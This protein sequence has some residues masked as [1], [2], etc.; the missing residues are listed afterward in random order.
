MESRL[1]EKMYFPRDIFPRHRIASKYDTTAIYI[2][3]GLDELLND[4]KGEILKDEKGEIVRVP[5]V[6]VPK[7][8]LDSA[9]ELFRLAHGGFASH[10]FITEQGCKGELNGIKAMLFVSA[11]YY[12]VNPEY[13]KDFESMEEKVREGLFLTECL[14]RVF[15]EQNIPE[16]SRNSYEELRQ[17]YQ[18]LYEIAEQANTNQ[19]YEQGDDD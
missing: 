8:Y 12:C 1:F 3:C 2:K 11:A 5:K 19:I 6:R 13:Y 4:D 16:K 17:V 7:G 14:P 9:I 10:D 15:E 18:H